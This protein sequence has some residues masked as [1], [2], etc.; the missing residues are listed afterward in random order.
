MVMAAGIPVDPYGTRSYIVPK[1]LKAPG[2][3]G[4]LHL[5]FASGSCLL[6]GVLLHRYVVDCCFVLTRIEWN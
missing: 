4:V 3:T 5:Q 2:T 1:V 6:Q